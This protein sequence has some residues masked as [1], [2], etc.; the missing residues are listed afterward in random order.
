MTETRIDRRFAALKKEGRPA[1]ATFVMAGDP[2]HETSLAIVRALPGAG[3]DVIE[4]GMPFSDPMADGPAVQMAGQR[5]LHGGETLRKTLDLVRA[6]REGDRDTPVV[7]MG[8]YNPIYAMGNERF[9]DAA[10]AAG[11]DG[12]IVVDLPPEA[13]DELCLPAIE[14]G[15]SFIRL[16]TPTTD[17]K[18]LPAVLA[19]TSGF[20]YYVSILGITGSASPDAVRVGEAVTRIKRHT[21]L[22][23]VVG[24]GVKTAAQAAA[25]GR[26]ADGVVVGSA[27]VAAVASSL[28][29][30]GR[31]T[32]GTVKAVTDLVADLAGGVR[33]A[34]AEAAE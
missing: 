3:A 29:A 18:R 31:A 5:A 30:E 11:V 20:V 27:I 16:A 7:L 21:I 28:D 25:L 4:I 8:Y 26:D 10:R 1:L 34:R 9:L 6:F 2:D 23:V 12:L 13:D 32:A 24:F 33:A 14:R 17:D 15:L 22:P 19:N